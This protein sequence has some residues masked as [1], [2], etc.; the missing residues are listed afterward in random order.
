MIYLDSAASTK[1]DDSVLNLFC[2]TTKKYYANPNS[3]HKLGLQAKEK[4]N[5]YTSKISDLLN[6][7]PDEVIYTSGASETNN[8]VVK[9]IADR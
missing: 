3:N 7:Y 6:I 4:I 8:L 1:V 5:E 9:G 2:E